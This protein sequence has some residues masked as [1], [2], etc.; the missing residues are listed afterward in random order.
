VP[1]RPEFGR[2][3]NLVAPTTASG[4][5]ELVFDPQA[6]AQPNGSVAAMSGETWYFQ[7]WFRAFQGT[8]TSNLTNGVAITFD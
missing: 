6:M 2:F 4:D 8:V 3:S 1:R 5:Y 7:A